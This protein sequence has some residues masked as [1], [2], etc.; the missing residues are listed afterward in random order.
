MLEKEFWRTILRPNIYGS[1]R[2]LEKR[3]NQEIFIF[4]ILFSRNSKKRI[5]E[6]KP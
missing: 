3:E 6:N 5:L 2:L 4:I 1:F